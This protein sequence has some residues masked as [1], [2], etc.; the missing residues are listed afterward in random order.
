MVGPSV[1]WGLPKLVVLRIGPAV[2]LPSCAH[3][4]SPGQARHA[5]GA[6]A[7]APGRG[8]TAE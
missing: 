7:A 6:V 2:F 3:E 1:S 5:K 8:G 4:A